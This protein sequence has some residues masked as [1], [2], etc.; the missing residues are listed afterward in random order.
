ME[1]AVFRPSKA[2]SISESSL[3]ARSRA[4]TAALWGQLGHPARL[5]APGGHPQPALGAQMGPSPVT[6]LCPPRASLSVGRAT[7]GIPAP[8][9]RASAWSSLHTIPSCVHVDWDWSRESGPSSL[10]LTGSYPAPV[11]GQGHR[12]G[13]KGRKH[14]LSEKGLYPKWTTWKTFKS[15]YKDKKCETQGDRGST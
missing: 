11:R 9:G 5:A 10:G 13:K 1:A 2:R 12:P 15:L 4:S 14:C 6:S 3:S 8:R 7:V